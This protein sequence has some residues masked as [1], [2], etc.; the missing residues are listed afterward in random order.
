MLRDVMFGNRR[1]FNEMLAS[2]EEGIASNILADRLQRL[3]RSGLLTRDEAGRGRK[4]TYSL[5]DAAI[6]LVPVFAELGAWGYG[7][8]QRAPSLRIA[9]NVS[10]RGDQNFGR[11]SWQNCASRTLLIGAQKKD[12]TVL[13]TGRRTALVDPDPRSPVGRGW[14]V[15][16][17]PDG[18]PALKLQ[19]DVGPLL[20]PYAPDGAPLPPPPGR[21]GALHARRERAPGRHASGHRERDA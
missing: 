4:A 12:R 8:D 6:E 11:S 1:H 18:R 13:T 14:P 9:P 5:T 15:R 2:S 21:R 16:L 19:R 7:T 20:S 3:V 10:R 17:T